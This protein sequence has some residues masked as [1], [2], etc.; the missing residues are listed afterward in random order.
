M[1]KKDGGHII[2]C[3]P[4]I[5]Y[6]NYKH[7]KGKTAYMISKIGMTLTALGVAEE[8]RGKGIS[9][10]TLWPMTPVESYALINHKL[11]EKKHWR[12]ADIISDCILNILKEDKN[13]F[14]GNELIDELYL[15]SKGVTDF[16]KYRC[17]PDYEPPKLNE[18]HKMWNA[19]VAPNKT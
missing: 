12:K 15:R 14:T 11:G 5:S 6:L 17:V 8:F 10:N 2:N 7:L 4:P 19:G 9:A 1:L 16:T 18:L 13:E 3:S